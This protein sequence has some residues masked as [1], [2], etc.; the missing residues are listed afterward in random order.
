MEGQRIKEI[1]DKWHS[2]NTLG[3]GL[4]SYKLNNQKQLEKY[5]IIYLS[6][7]K[8]MALNDKEFLSEDSNHSEQQGK[9]PNAYR[10]DDDNNLTEADLQHG[11][12]ASKN[13]MKKQDA[14]GME[15]HGMGG[16]SFGENSL[17]PSGDDEANPL[18]KVAYINAHFKQT[19][20][21]EEHLE[22]SH[23]KDPDQL[24]QLNDDAAA[25]AAANRRPDEGGDGTTNVCDHIQQTR[26]TYQEGAADS[27]GNNNG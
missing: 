19:Q 27:D 4:F 16:H 6:T 13:D 14:P 22:N 21:I 26:Q 15:G 10:V 17:T 3:L 9:K 18:L 12:P 1:F 2:L 25:V 11:F 20:P 8:T 5:G 24:G 7:Y 23:F